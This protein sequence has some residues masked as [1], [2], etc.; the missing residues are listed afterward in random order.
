MA[1]AVDTTLQPEARIDA[2]SRF[3]GLLNQAEPAVKRRF[4][5]TV[6]RARAASDIAELERIGDLLSSGQID[7]A[8]QIAD[9]IGPSLASTLESVYASFGLSAAAVLR[10]QVDT[11][12]DFS[13]LN[14]RAVRDLSET[15][16]R[17]VR[18][19]TQGQRTAAMEILSDSFQ[20][21]LPPIE[22]ARR[23]KQSI[24]LTG[25]QGQV[26]ANYRRALETGSADALQRQLRDRRFDPTVRRALATN[27]NRVPLTTAQIDRMVERYTERWVAFRSETIARTETLAAASAGDLELWR[28]AVDAEVVD[29]EDIVSVWHTA[30]D[31]R[32]RSSHNFMHLQERPIGEPFLSGDGNLLRFPAD[33]AAP[34]SDVIRCRCVVAREISA[35][36]RTR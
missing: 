6:G 7:E 24:G 23:L 27:P 29:P 2:L 8:L 25:Y 1:F 20:R 16:L 5:E 33:P 4:L 32:V 35:D 10:S 17:L 34:A 18:E 19:F 26:V 14:A 22:Q 15:R 9:D 21:G 12:F 36:A 3:L 13:T 30:A 31:E 28:Q 11:A